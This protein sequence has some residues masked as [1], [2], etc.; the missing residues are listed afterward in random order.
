MYLANGGKK[1]SHKNDVVQLKEENVYPKGQ[2]ILTIGDPDNQRPDK[3]NSTVS[4]SRS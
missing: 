3:W 2:A 1:L 4:T